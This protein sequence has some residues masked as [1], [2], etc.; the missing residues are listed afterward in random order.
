VLFAGVVFLLAVR[1]EYIGEVVCDG[2]HKCWS[3]PASSS[4]TEVSTV[5]CLVGLGIWEV[6]L[7]GGRGS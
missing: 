5:S 4:I 2:A 1:L 3:F 7:V 6:V